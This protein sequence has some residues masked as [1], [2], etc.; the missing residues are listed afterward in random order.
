M[1]FAL[2]RFP[3]PAPSPPPL[4][5]SLHSKL[6]SNVSRTLSTWWTAIPPPQPATRTHAP[7]W[8]R[9][10]AAR[11]ESPQNSAICNI[12]EHTTIRFRDQCVPTALWSN[13]LSRSCIAVWD[14]VSI[15][16]PI[17]CDA[18]PNGAF[19]LFFSFVFK[20]VERLT[21]ATLILTV[22]PPTHIAVL[23]ALNRTLSFI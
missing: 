14:N 21:D 9:Y 20:L 19:P 3:C 2:E 18:D 16:S 6:L 1:P 15:I 10:R 23:N 5:L 12:I 13:R 8:N 4:F 17:S 7:K 11:D 22:S